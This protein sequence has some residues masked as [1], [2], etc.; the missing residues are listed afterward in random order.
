MTY[1]AAEDVIQ[2]YGA[3]ALSVIA[4]RD[5]DYKPDHA[6]IDGALLRAAAEIDA[7]LGVRFALP[8]PHRSELLVQIAADIA[9]Y[10]MA[11]GA[12]GLTDEHRTRYEDAI[13]M[14]RDI[15]AGKASLPMPPTEPE[16]GEERLEQD[17]P[18][19]VVVTGPDRLF[20]RAQMRG[21]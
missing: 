11:V 10:R 21:L 3:D 7:Y 8:L 13:K 4:D 6:V 9:V 15:G 5:G 18:A 17:S 16:P 19:P 14:L 2:L 1:A 12:G 20:S